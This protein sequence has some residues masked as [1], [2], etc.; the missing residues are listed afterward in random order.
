MFDPQEHRIL[1]HLDDPLR[2]FYWTMD[3]ALVLLL[4][5]FIGTAMDHPFLGI[6]C[7]LLGTWALVKLKKRIG[8]G[9]LR[10]AFY[11]FFP[12]NPRLYS[13]TPPSFIREYIG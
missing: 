9:T 6:G 2:I 10:H 3:E 7:S 13:M 4:S 8:G 5:P 1:H 12:H 11:W